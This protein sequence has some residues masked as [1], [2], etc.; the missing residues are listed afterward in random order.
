MN[1]HL[2]KILNLSQKTGDRLIV[3][4]SSGNNDP[5]VILPVDEYEQL[6]G[7]EDNVS[8]LTE[9]QL[10]DRINRDIANWKA[11]KKDVEIE[12]LPSFETEPSAPSFGFLDDDLY[13]DDLEDEVYGEN[14]DE[15]YDLE[16]EKDENTDFE[17]IKDIKGSEKKGKSH[18][19]IPSERKEA[20]EEVIEED[21]QYLEDLPF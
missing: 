12:K 15:D 13:D 7:F 16:F 11:G 1:H 19:Q 9:G 17:S 6:L 18:W 3:V 10:I 20:A 2:Q 14:F 21:R 4:D 8:D 5:F